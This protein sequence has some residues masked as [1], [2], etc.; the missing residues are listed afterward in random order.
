MSKEVKAK[1]RSQ[2]SVGSDETGEPV[3]E[4]QNPVLISLLTPGKATLIILSEECREL[5]VTKHQDH[6]C[7]QT[8]R[9]CDLSAMPQSSSAFQ[10]SGG[11]RVNAR[12]F[13]EN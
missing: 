8:T 4:S 13:S 6:T 12:T 11:V 3:T 5:Q 10:T 1:V 9:M 7:S 2:S